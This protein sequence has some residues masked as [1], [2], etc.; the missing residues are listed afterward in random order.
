MVTI[1]QWAGTG[2]AITMISDESGC[3]IPIPASAVWSFAVWA[4]DLGFK[5]FGAV[6]NALENESL[7]M[8]LGKCT[9]EIMTKDGVVTGTML[10]VESSIDCLR[11]QGT[12]PVALN[13]QT[14][15][16]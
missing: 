3:R 7:P 12:G 8:Y 4:D 11:L 15:Q 9:V 13:G 10:A 1:R 5:T 2:D 16:D 14:I 6:I